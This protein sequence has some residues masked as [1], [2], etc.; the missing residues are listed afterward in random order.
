[1]DDETRVFLQGLSLTPSGEKL[2][3]RDYQINIA[4]S[5]L[6]RGNSLVI[7]PTALGK[8]YVAIFVIAKIVRDML[9]GT[10]PRKKILFLAPT[11]PLAS[12]QARKISEFVDFGSGGNKEGN[13]GADMQYAQSE[14]AG[15]GLE[16]NICGASKGKIGEDGGKPAK[17]RGVRK[18][19][20]ADLGLVPGV[21]VMTGET[22]PEK[23]ERLWGLEE[24]WC[25][26]AT[27]QT[28]EFDVLAG[29]V[30]LN[31]IGLV[32]LDEAHRAVKEYS[33]SFIAREAAKTNAL[34]V[35]LTASPSGKREMIDEICANLQIQNIEIRDESDKDV[36]KYAHDIRVEWVFVE[37]PE[38]LKRIQRQIFELLKEVLEQ[39]RGL[40]A[41]DSTE[42]RGHRRGLLELRRRVLQNI[43]N[44]P[45]NYQILSLHAKAMNISHAAD[46]IEIEGV[47][48][49]LEFMRQMEG[50]S[51]QS[52]AVRSLLGDV[53]W[54]KAQQECMELNERGEEHPKFAKLYEIL[55][56]NEN[57]KG[58]T[59][60]FAHYRTTVARIVSGLKEIEGLRPVEFIGKGKGGMGQKQQQQVLQKFRGGE[61]NVLVATSVAEEGLDIPEVGLVIFFEAVPS[62]IRLI[63][64]R[65]RTGRVREGK[66]I[67]LVAKGS[68][69][70]AMFWASRN[71]EKKMRQVVEGMRDEFRAPEKR[72]SNNWK[73]RQTTLEF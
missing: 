1:M 62:E 23:R 44:D 20:S 66:A 8:T 72:D 24:A 30:D 51:G 59:I 18:D 26:C 7:M 71:K 19:E 48:T 12:Q 17:K 16:V 39:L 2:E 29:R 9:N 58:Q 11:K 50:R 65:G 45:S 28:V 67:I 69:D 4:K 36:R 61:F 70:E 56:E 49:L 52:K 3:A 25:Y 73:A 22:P 14:R 15:G 41:V 38:G 34:L 35:G 64:R 27:P 47:G 33:Y 13:L 10:M 21:T 32:V 54:L 53:R 55:K 43:H 5:I 40:G 31:N 42:L 68:K 6:R 37:L 46:L 63:Q 60:V 57:K